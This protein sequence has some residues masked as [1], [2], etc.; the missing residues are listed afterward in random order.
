MK[1]WLDV[2]VKGEDDPAILEKIQ[3]QYAA[4]PQHGRIMKVEKVTP[5]WYAPLDKFIDEI[6]DEFIKNPVQ[7]NKVDKLIKN[8]VEN[9]L[10]QYHDQIAK[11]WTNSATTNS[12]NLLR[13]KFPTICK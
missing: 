9:L 13:R 1:T 7:Q 4:N 3:R 12:R 2:N 10:T 8:F 6:I 5:I 11:G